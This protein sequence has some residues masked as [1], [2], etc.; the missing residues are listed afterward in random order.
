MGGNTHPKQISLFD[1]VENGG[2]RERERESKRLPRHIF[3]TIISVENLLAAWREF[4]RG[5]RNRKDVVIFA[6]HL[7]DNVLGLHR[8]LADRTYRHGPYRAF[9]VNDPKP[10]DIHKA[11]VRDRLVHHAICRILYP[12]FDRKFIFDSYSCRR[13]K[14]THRALNRFREYA[15]QVSYNHT[16]TAWVLQCDIKKFFASIDHATLK[17]ILGRHSADKDVVWFLGEVIDSF[18]TKNVFGVGLPL[19]NLTSQLF[20]NIYLNELD[21]FLKREG[22]VRFYIRYADD[23]VI[24]HENRGFLEHILRKISGFLATRLNLALHPG[25]I[26]IKTLTSGVD[27]L[28]W[29]HFPHHRILR[30]NTKRRILKRFSVDI[31]PK[32]RVSYRGLLLHGNTFKVARALSFFSD[33]G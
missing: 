11:S 21:Q 14:G 32:A 24:L 3:H 10:R 6:A 27:F 19:G 18:H 31:T 17:T 2:M 13:N 8:E 7:T 28:G 5:K 23:F 33:A 12:Y 20:V 22:R 9:R 30:T 26:F 29:M 25:K 15:R 16:R 1:S 4:L